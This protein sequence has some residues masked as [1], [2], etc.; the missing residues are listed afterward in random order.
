MSRG[1]PQGCQKSAAGGPWR[2]KMNARRRQE[3]EN[4]PPEA[5][6]ARQKTPGGPEAPQESPRGPPRAAKSSP[7]GPWKNTPARSIVKHGVLQPRTLKNLGLAAFLNQFSQPNRCFL[8]LEALKHSVL[9]V[10]A[11]AKRAKTR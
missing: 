1:R 11:R 4:E 6:G 9:R 7:G 8:M 5:P 2:A 3:T 10:P